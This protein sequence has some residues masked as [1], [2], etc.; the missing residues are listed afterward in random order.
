[1]C[2]KSFCQESHYDYNNLLETYYILF[3]CTEEEWVSIRLGIVISFDWT[4]PVFTAN[5]FL[6][7]FGYKHTTYIYITLIV[8]YNNKVLLYAGLRDLATVW[9]LGQNIIVH[10][11]WFTF[12]ITIQYVWYMLFVLS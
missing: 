8:L 10:A 6:V 7:R 9:V 2:L 12:S 5:A 4:E 11:P 1:M 3:V